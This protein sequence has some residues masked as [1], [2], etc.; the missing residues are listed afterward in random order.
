MKHILFLTIIFIFSFTVVYSEYQKI[1]FDEVEERVLGIKESENKEVIFWSMIGFFSDYGYNFV[2]V[3]DYQIYCNQIGFYFKVSIIDNSND[4]ILAGLY[5]IPHFRVFDTID[6][7]LFQTPTALNE[8]ICLCE[9]TSGYPIIDLIEGQFSCSSMMPDGERDDHYA[10]IDCHDADYAI[11]FF[12]RY[13]KKGLRF[14]DQ[15]SIVE[16]IIFGEQRE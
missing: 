12:K 5:F 1:T 15:I 3:S 11:I 13:H 7:E 9:T 10:I 16:P 2:G 8:H 6:G 14:K 4:V